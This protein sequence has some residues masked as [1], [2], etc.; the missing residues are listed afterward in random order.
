[1]KMTRL[2]H[3]SLLSLFCKENIISLATG[4]YLHIQ[5]H[6]FRLSQ[7]CWYMV[8]GRLPCIARGSFPWHLQKNI[9]QSCSLIWQRK[10]NFVLRE[11]GMHV[12]IIESILTSSEDGFNLKVRQSLCG[13]VF[14]KL[15]KLRES[16]FSSHPCAKCFFNR[17]NR[18][19]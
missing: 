1:M 9:P 18:K 14:S 13:G 19:K 11:K 10:S 12:I 2:R 4:T 16:F 8:T 17:A 3:S 15:K 6:L 7:H 5:P